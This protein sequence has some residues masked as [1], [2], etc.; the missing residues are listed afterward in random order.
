VGERSRAD[1]VLVSMPF[2]PLLQP[3]LALSILASF[4]RQS[5]A[6]VRVEYLTFDFARR[7]GVPPYLDLL[8]GGPFS[9][10]LPGEFVFASAVSPNAG[11]DLEAYLDDIYASVASSR[12]IAPRP[13]MVR[14]ALRALL[15]CARAE[16]DAFLADATERVLGANP[17]VVGFS[18][19]FQQQLSSLALA[20]RIK[21][22]APDTVTV[23]GGA[24]CEPPM[25][26]EVLA[27][28]AAVDAVVPGEGEPVFPELVTRVLEHRPWHTVP[29]LLTRRQLLP[30]VG[31]QVHEL[32]TSPLPDYDDYFAQLHGAELD[33][34]SPPQLLIET[35][36]GC[37]WG[38]RRHCTFCGIEKGRM[39]FRSKSPERV[40]AEIA[41]LRDRYPGLAIAAVDNIMD[42]S[43]FDTV[44]PALA[45]SRGGGEL[46]YEVKA[47]LSRAQV[48]ALRDAGIPEIQP[49]IESLA[50]GVLRLMRK[51][52]TAMQNVQLLKWC[53]EL[54]VRPAWNVLWGFPGEDP[55]EYAD[56][57]A[58]V[59]LLSHLRPPMWAGP[60]R[61]DR[62]SPLFEDPGA[63]GVSGTRPAVAYR[64]LY[65]LPTASV[66]RLAYF[67]V[68]DP[69]P[70]PTYVE[71]LRSSIATWMQAAPSSAFFSIDAKDRLVLFDLRPIAERP[72]VE[73]RGVARRLYLACADARTESALLCEF[74]DVDPERLMD[75]LGKLVDDRLML[76]LRKSYLALALP[77]GDYQPSRAVMD[78]LATVL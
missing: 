28:F 65:A 42:R 71:A 15:E 33:V 22:A 51:G 24:N 55:A 48:R 43:Y 63:H 30:P 25:G 46:F 60:L 27:C 3:S 62:F 36:R 49:G 14:E 69:A 64:H 9:S 70:A 20:G 6:I 2:G 41:H 5:G 31:V 16:V 10:A 1:V 35:S 40:L 56:M 78:R 54:G 13:P 37:W 23:F 47:N 59:P 11:R 53:A 61:L 67:F 17:S 57:A 76:R 74:D 34:M 45:A 21:A 38:E 29:G 26:K 68:P 12:S 7:I 4:T 18:S 66:A 72:V 52:V 58:M 77:V 32:D 8:S 39:A 75:E 44:L 19:T 50:D 73:L